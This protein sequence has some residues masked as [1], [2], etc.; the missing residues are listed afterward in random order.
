MKKLHFAL[1][2]MGKHG[3]RWAGVVSK[4]ASLDAVVDP[5]IEGSATLEDVLSDPY[6]DAVL[7]AVPHKYHAEIT[8]KALLAGKHVLCEKPG[9]IY[10]D[11]MRENFKIAK[12]KRLKYMIGYNYRFHDAFIKARK[13]YKKGAI[14]KLVFIRA[15]HGFGGRKGYGKEWRINKE[16]SGGGHLHDQGTHMVNMAKSFIGQLK[17]AKGMI[18]DNYWKSGTEDNGFVLL[19]GKNNVIASIHSSLTQ[20]DRLHEFE[21]YGTKG[22]LKV[23]GLGMRYGIDEHLILGKRTNNPDVVKEKW[24]DCDAIADH[25]LELELKEFTSWINKNKNITPLMLDAYMTLKVIENVY[26]EDKI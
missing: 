2:G 25:S 18:A 24:I 3:S 1:I 4:I 9:A 14:G 5:N 16:I 17:T 23:E 22:Y 20:W 13:L 8:K 19:K 11:E 10:S 15:R 26:I 21:I 12:K 6:I 7:I